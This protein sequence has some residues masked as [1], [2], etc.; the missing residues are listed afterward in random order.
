MELE[1]IKKSGENTPHKL[2]RPVYVATSLP[3]RSTSP[4]PVQES[5]QRKIV[6]N[7]WYDQYGIR[8]TYKEENKVLMICASEVFPDS[9]VDYINSLP[10]NLG[11]T[12]VLKVSSRKNEVA[13]FNVLCDTLSRSHLNKN[14]I[15]S[16]ED[17]R[18][19]RGVS[20]D[21]ERL[22]E[23]VKISNVMNYEGKEEGYYGENSLDW[24]GLNLSTEDYMVFQRRLTPLAAQ[25]AQELRTIAYSAYCKFKNLG[26]DKLTINQRA[27]LI[28]DWCEGKFDEGRGRIAY[29]NE[30]TMSDGS[31]NYDC[32]YS[33]D[34]IATFHRKKGV[35]A[36]RARLLKV[37]LNNYFMR[38]PCY[39]VGGM[40]GRLQHEWNEVVDEQGRLTFYDLSHEGGIHNIQHDDFELS[41]PYLPQCNRKEKA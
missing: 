34:P 25:R 6:P 15:I 29:D 40:A 36:G 17:M 14:I 12:I 23:T 32:R 2:A 35:C 41:K 27:K 20:L 31:F 5:V 37:Y 9:I 30:S 13:G 19:G 18:F 26:I 11:I 39:L 22:P 24:W 16:T 3:R 21:I 10:G 33:Q 28:F 38:V 1:I 7:D 8:Y 4:A